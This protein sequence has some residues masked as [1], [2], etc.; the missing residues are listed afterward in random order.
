VAQNPSALLDPLSH[1]ELQEMLADVPTL[2]ELEDGS[3]LVTLRPNELAMKRQKMVTE[4]PS[5]LIAVA[6]FSAL[7]QF[8]RGGSSPVQ[9][10]PQTQAHSQPS[11]DPQQTLSSPTNSQTATAE[12]TGTATKMR[13][14]RKSI[15]S[16]ADLILAAGLLSPPVAA[17]VRKAATSK[18]A[19]APNPGDALVSGALAEARVPAR[20]V[21][22]AVRELVQA[23]SVCPLRAGTDE[24]VRFA[25]SEGLPTVV[26]CDRGWGLE[27][28]ACRALF[29]QV[30][31]LA[32]AA[33]DTND[34]QLP[35]TFLLVGSTR[36]S[37]G[38]DG[39]VT[40]VAAAGESPGFGFGGG[41]DGTLG[42]GDRPVFCQRLAVA[43]ALQLLE[44]KLSHPKRAELSAALRGRRNAVVIEVVG[45]AAESGGNRESALT[46]GAE[47]LETVIRVGLLEPGPDL[48]S[49]L[50]SLQEN[51]G[52]AGVESR[53]GRYDVVVIGEAGLGYVTGLLREVITGSAPPTLGK[54]ALQREREAQ[55]EARAQ[56]EAE[57]MREIQAYSFGGM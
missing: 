28:V 42:N 8:R 32:G 22:R 37:V 7:V 55:E 51:N 50:Q 29:T 44:R 13:R 34:P 53:S 31:R 1:S 24:L 43:S 48:V 46:Q 2:V 35:P 23:G 3:T 40:G 11:F 30:N 56:A 54:A 49:R 9:S 10:H 45:A 25:G 19:V 12:S 26:L 36:L 18:P 27:D 52:V 17:Q 5:Q 57:Q 4:G 14:A 16:S 21:F 41:G 15:L 20:E 38:A 33:D 47:G 39:V 6:E